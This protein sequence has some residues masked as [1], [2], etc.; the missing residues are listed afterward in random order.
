MTILERVNTDIKS[1]MKNRE[2]TKL[3]ALKQI[4]TCVVNFSKK[5]EGVENPT[6]EELY[7]I[8]EAHIAK[9]KNVI[10]TFEKAEKSG[11]DVGDSIEDET[12]EMELTILYLPEETQA[13]L[14]TKPLTDVELKEKITSIID[15]NSF[16]GMKDMG[17]VM[18][19]LKDVA[20]VNMK[21]AGN[22]VKLLLN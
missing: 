11:L 6:D 16:S 4:K 22:L 10:T 14:N 15:E 13:I 20:G 19:A 7:P 18:G 3:I 1:A 8:L 12:L 9:R 21:I 5:E 17:K 2:K